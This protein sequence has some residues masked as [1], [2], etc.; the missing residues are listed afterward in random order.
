MSQM[1]TVERYIFKGKRAII[2]VD[3]NVPLDNNYN[4]TDDSR[5][6]AVLPTIEKILKDGG[7]VILM[8]HLGRPKEGPEDR[9]SLRYLVNH[10]SKLLGRKVYFADDC[11]GNSAVEMSG[12]LKPGG[13]LLLENLRFHKEETRGDRDFAR[14]LA[15]LADV[16]VND[17]FGT[18]H[19][20]HAST[21]IIA[22]FFPEDK[23]FGLLM[24]RELSSI[25]KV[26]S[27]IK[28]PYVAIIG[29]AKISTKI[30]V[31]NNLVDKVDDL[32][33]GGGMMFT[34]IKANG[35][36]IGKSLSEDDYLETAREIISLAKSKNVN[37]H[38]PV[39]AIIADDF[40]NDANTRVCKSDQIPDGWMGM[41][42]GEKARQ[43]FSSIIIKA[44]NILWNGPMGVT[45][46]SEF[47][48][49]TKSIV[50][51]MAEATSG[52]AFTL[53]GGGDSVAAINQLG[54]ADK[55]SYVSTGGG[56]LL[57]FMEGKELPGVEAIMKN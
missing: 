48:A 14:K 35:G 50:R 34:F 6:R 3:F 32:I 13:V 42:I 17:A 11:V 8:S 49:G 47:V 1:K 10:L 55:V 57:E 18:A 54:M 27:D 12:K 44:K 31:L 4:V 25:K 23:M 40:S 53:V 33:I 41:D 28:R 21:T 22:E 15:D 36:K 16:Y 52:G 2:R 43:N 20:A 51:S 26:L 24:A 38:L 46:M 39:D 19:R 29:G 45:E 9:Y 5:I 56:A 37:I 7:S 30:D